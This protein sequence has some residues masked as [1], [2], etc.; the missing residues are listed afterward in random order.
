MV[1]F[2]ASKF[3]LQV[4]IRVQH[5]RAVK[6]EGRRSQCLYGPGQAWRACFWC[7]ACKVLVQW[8][9][10][11]VTLSHLAREL[12][13]RYFSSV[14]A[15]HFLLNHIWFYT[16]FFCF[17]FFGIFS[18]IIVTLPFPLNCLTVATTTYIFSLVVPSC[19][20]IISLAVLVSRSTRW[21][22]W[23]HLHCQ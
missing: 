7:D 5:Q 3:S 23:T 22:R 2:I 6:E 20:Q 1:L 18:C 11:R 17:C 12:Q 10:L 19:D 15:R 14:P 8:Y 21:V 13:V 4:L 16:F 9:Y